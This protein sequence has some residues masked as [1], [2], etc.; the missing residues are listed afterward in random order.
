[1]T[2]I[3]LTKKRILCSMEYEKPTDQRIINNGSSFVLQHGASEQRND[4]SNK[5]DP[6]QACH[7][8]NYYL[9]SRKVSVNH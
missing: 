8:Y 3:L 4:T 5:S 7:L 6:V 1:M 2:Y 9:N